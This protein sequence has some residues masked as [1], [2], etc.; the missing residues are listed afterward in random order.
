MARGS[1]R[2]LAVALVCLG[3]FGGCTQ[4][5]GDA[6]SASR[7]HTRGTNTEG[8]TGTDQP[9]PP[10]PPKTNLPARMRSLE[11]SDVPLL[12]VDPDVSALA[13]GPPARLPWFEYLGNPEFGRT[14]AH[15]RDTEFAVR[16]HVYPRRLLW[17]GGGLA[18]IAGVHT[19]DMWVTIDLDGGVTWVPRTREAI[20]ETVAFGSDRIAWTHPA[21]SPQTGPV[22]EVLQRGSAEPQPVALPSWLDADHAAQVA[23]AFFRRNGELVVRVVGSVPAP[24]GFLLSTLT[25]EILPLP[26][27]KPV[28]SGSASEVVLVE[29]RRRG[30]IWAY[31]VET[32]APLWSRS[33]T[34]GGRASC[35]R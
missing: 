17:W 16:T 30:D 9:L 25:G 24:S 35:L 8:A 21:R 18:G 7:P 31:D 2:L 4:S 32:F 1:S 3:C 29:G 14:I 13:E 12:R 23:P 34:Q 10:G 33:F 6:Q 27:A 22:V 5:G 20:R 28:V 11:L 26:A 15:W 19:V